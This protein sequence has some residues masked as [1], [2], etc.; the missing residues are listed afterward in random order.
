[1]NGNE[2]SS[3][4]FNAYDIKRTLE[5]YTS[6]DDEGKEVNTKDLKRIHGGTENE[7]TLEEL[8]SDVILFLKKLE[9][10]S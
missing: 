1:M 9:E 6:L 2:I 5:S 7:E 8:I 10:Q 4:L 3:A